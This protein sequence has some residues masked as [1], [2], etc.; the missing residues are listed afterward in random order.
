MLTD[1]AA[2]TDREWLSRWDRQQ[3]G[4][5]ADREGRYSAMTDLLRAL[6]GDGAGRTVLDLGCGPG[7][8]TDRVLRALP[9]VQVVAVDLD[10]V[11]IELARRTAVDP[12]RV[13]HV[14][15]D[16][17]SRGWVE[18]VTAAA[19]DGI[20]AVVSTTA[21]HWLTAGALTEVYRAAFDLLSPGGVLLN[22]DHM[23]Y[24]ADQP[25][26]AK[27]TRSLQDDR[28]ATAFGADGTDDYAAWHAAL[29]AAAPELP[30]DERERRFAGL[31]RDDRGTGLT[32]H[33]A[34][35]RDAG[36]T[37][38]DTVWQH[39]DDRVLCAVKG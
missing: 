14:E 39:F 37:E 36:F 34:A 26:L 12:G 4:Y 10:P 18:Q 21:L 1:T 5:M 8:T 32:L 28:E 19:P 6:L 25:V 16:L 27:V 13:L 11:L 31:P 3:Q 33:A 24:A 38:V 7:S 2:E 29:R 17:A 15:A 23:R 20:A 35:L 9:S 30:W 22:G